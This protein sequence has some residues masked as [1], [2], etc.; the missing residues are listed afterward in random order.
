MATP[1]LL[2][3]AMYILCH[4]HVYVLSFSAKNI[5]NVKEKGYVHVP[6]PT[7]IHKSRIHV[8]GILHLHERVW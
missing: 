3:K 5:N 6:I 2:V 4:V 1:I 8:G 7:C